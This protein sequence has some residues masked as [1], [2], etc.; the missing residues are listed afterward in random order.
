MISRSCS[1]QLF[2]VWLLVPLELFLEY[3]VLGSYVMRKVVL[4]PFCWL[5]V[6]LGRLAIQTSTMQAPMGAT[7]GCTGMLEEVMLHRQ[8][9][10]NKKHM[11]VLGMCIT[12]FN[13][14]FPDL[15]IKAGWN[16][17]QINEP[18]QKYKTLESERNQEN[19]AW[20]LLQV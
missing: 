8:R 7:G 17:L 16:S 11:L 9:Q 15:K 20:K 3:L 5:L 13:M 2:L 1:L 14:C 10:R 6:Q 12:G 19:Q 4:M 18:K